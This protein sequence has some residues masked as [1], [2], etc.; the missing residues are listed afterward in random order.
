[1]LMRT[2]YGKGGLPMT[3]SIVAL[4]HSPQC[5][6]S[7]PWLKLGDGSQVSHHRVTDKARLACVGFCICYYIDVLLWQ[8]GDSH[9]HSLIKLGSSGRRQ[10]SPW[11]ACQGP[12][13]KLQFLLNNLFWKRF[14]KVELSVQ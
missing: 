13:Q 8:V 10:G 1:T 4:V 7:L 2:N 9:L 6:M 12:Q 14:T 3:S 11:G 5:D